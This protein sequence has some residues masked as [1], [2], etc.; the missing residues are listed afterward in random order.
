[1]RQAVLSFFE[2]MEDDTDLSFVGSGPRDYGC[3][4][5]NHDLFHQRQGCSSARMRRGAVSPNGRFG[6]PLKSRKE[7]VPTE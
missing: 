3:L 5:G 2:R 6:N 4:H 1:M 7:E